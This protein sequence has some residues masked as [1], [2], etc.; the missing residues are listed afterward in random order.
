[1]S[2]I[3]KTTQDGLVFES[4]CYLLRLFGRRVALPGWL[5]PGR[6]TVGHHDR[7]GGTFDF[8]LTLRHA[9]FGTLLD[10]RIRFQDMETLR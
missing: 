10:Q 3:V 9:L 7:A 6:L 5:T 8:T 1:M 2:L 4:D